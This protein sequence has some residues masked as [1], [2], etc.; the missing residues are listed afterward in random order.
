MNQI[1]L[2]NQLIEAIKDGD[3]TIVK[4]L[5]ERGANV[6]HASIVG[7]TPLIIAGNRGHLEIVKYLIEHGAD[8]NQANNKGNT[9]LTWASAQ[10][11]LSLQM[12][13]ARFEIVKYLIEQGANVNHVNR[14]GYSP[15]IYASKNGNLDIVKYLIKNGANVNHANNYGD[16]PLT[17]ASHNGHLEIVKYLTEHGADYTPLKNDPLFREILN[18]IINEETNKLKYE[19]TQNYLTIER[20]TPQTITGEGKV[21]SLLPKNL[22]LKTVYEKPYQELCVPSG[23]GLPPIQLIALANILRLD[24]NIDITWLELCD[25]IKHVLYLLL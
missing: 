20:G 19:L 21:K 8:V 2:D 9:S 24:Y 23:Q 4:D 5:I 14:N 1:E 7:D 25:R 16:T 6:N 12:N 13:N 3:I 17:L 22:L 11:F 18:E 15:L 10:S